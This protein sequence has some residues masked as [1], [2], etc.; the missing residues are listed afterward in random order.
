[1]H[2]VLVPYKGWWK[3]HQANTS[4]SHLIKAGLPLLLMPISGVRSQAFLTV[5]DAW[6]EEPMSKVEEALRRASV[7]MLW[8][9]WIIGK[10]LRRQMAT[11]GAVTQRRRG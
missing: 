2:A 6:P 4:S 8:V 9:L 7:V 10:T 11:L 1:M 5:T 3:K